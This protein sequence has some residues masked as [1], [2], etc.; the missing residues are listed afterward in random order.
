[1]NEEIVAQ[2]E[3]W[4]N[5]ADAFSRIYS[6]R[7]SKLSNMLD[8]VFRKD[9]YDRYVFTIKNCEPIQGRT[10]L[11]VGCGNGLYSLELAR[12]GA[13]KVVG[14][15]IA[16]VMIGLC[17]DAAEKEH[18]DDRC[19]FEQTD[20]LEY[21]GKSKFDVSFGIGLF[22]YISDPLPVLKKMREL[23]TD[24]AIMA[25]PRFWTWRAPIRKVRLNSRGCDVYFY[26]KERI[27]ELMD[28]AGFKRHEV[29]KV[30]KLHCVIAYP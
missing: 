14:I 24:K 29:H 28:Q 22:D 1:M 15:D 17:K 2:R 11:Y 19:L 12:K 4:N 25:F 23:S 9:M 20:L 26:T 8:S 3:Y 5:E 30:G 6:H 7:K 27:K 21:E 10:F 16:E 18:L 13:K